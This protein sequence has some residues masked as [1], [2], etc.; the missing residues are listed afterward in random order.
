[1]RDY[2]QQFLL[3][4]DPP[5][6][7][8][9]P[10]EMV[11]CFEDIEV[12]TNDA[13]VTTSC[14]DHS[15][16]IYILPPEVNGPENCPGTTY[17]FTYRVIDNC[18][19]TTEVTRTFTIG[20]NDAPTITAPL[21][22]TCSCLAGVNANPENAIV[23]TACGNGVGYSVEVSGPIVNGPMDCPGTTYTYTYTVTDDCGRTASDNQVF[24]VQNDPPTINCPNDL[25]FNDCE[26]GNYLDII[27]A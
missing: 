4:N 8:V 25:Q 12:S 18:T 11:E 6:V 21:D 22:V 1:M 9:P 24:T 10:G 14:D 2:L 23:T 7:S 20:N 5:T 13:T 26:G 19:R 15:Y 16:N 3:Q 17:T 27:Y